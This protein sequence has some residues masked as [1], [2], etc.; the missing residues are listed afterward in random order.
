VI[1]AVLVM[2]VFATTASAAPTWSEPVTFGAAGRYPGPTQV[3]VTPAGEAI[4]VWEGGQP[5]GI[6]FAAWRPGLGWS[7]AQALASRG[8][9]PQ[10]AAAGPKAVVV[11]S[12]T[13]KAQSGEASVV[14]ASTRLRGGRW[15]EPENISAE[16]RWRFEPEAD[17]PQI[18]ITTR[19]EA[20]AMWT[21]GDEGHSTTPF[22][23]AATQSP[24]GSWSAPVGLRGSIEGEEPQ[25]EVTPGGEGV[26]VWHAYYNEESGLETATRPVGGKWT[27]VKRL[28]NPGAFPNPKLAMTPSGE[29][30]ATWEFEL[31]GGFQVAARRPGQRW[32]EVR[33][34]TPPD[35]GRYYDPRIVTK[36]GRPAL[37]WRRLLG[38][39][40]EDDA[41]VTMPR[42]AGSTKPASLFGAGV[43]A[44]GPLVAVTK[45]GEWIAIWSSTGPAEETMVETASRRPGQPWSAPVTL[46]AWPPAP[47]PESPEVEIALAPDGEVVAL[48]RRYDGTRWVLQSATR[49][50]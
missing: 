4:A 11:W 38:A 50:Q 3:A 12:D 41:V 25:L 40:V 14:F 42:G 43:E 7:R 23:R 27:Y 45:G 24:R 47:D 22:I 20:I 32:G 21:A 10:I 8:S 19:G 2:A 18:A 44:R 28:A 49:S 9:E 29:A 15:S 33:T 34:F 1:A 39:E 5:R 48:W 30:I 31:G 17:A 35:G 13:I 6:Q 37:T 16:K 26:A 36:P 46:S